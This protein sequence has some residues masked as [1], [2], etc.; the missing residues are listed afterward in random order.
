M[1]GEDVFFS[2][3]VWSDNEYDVS[4][5]NKPSDVM[6]LDTLSDNIILAELPDDDE[7]FFDA[8]EFLDLND[9]PDPDM[10]LNFHS[11]KD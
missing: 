2:Q 11:R 9:D 8:N 5:G 10:G 6:G 7:E 4:L 3:S 1:Y